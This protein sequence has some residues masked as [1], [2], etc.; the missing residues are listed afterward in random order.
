MRLKNCQKTA[1]E[2]TIVNEHRFYLLDFHDFYEYED[3]TSYKRQFN[4]YNPV[5]GKEVV[6]AFSIPAE[7]E[8]LL[9][10]YL[11]VMGEQ[12]IDIGVYFQ[13]KDGETTRLSVEGEVQ[14]VKMSL[15]RVLINMREIYKGNVYNSNKFL[16]KELRLLNDGDHDCGFEIE[17]PSFDQCD[18]KITP[19]KGIVKKHSF[20]RM[21]LLMEPIKTGEFDFCIKW[22]Y[23]DDLKAHPDLYIEQSDNIQFNKE[24]GGKSLIK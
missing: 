1:A 24:E 4:I 12:P 7:G 18:I 15:N 21:D 9:D 14:D 19:L 3:E 23:F 16:S 2:V 13:V 11:N 20:Q 10:C 6:E 17:P 8:V 22:K 5:T